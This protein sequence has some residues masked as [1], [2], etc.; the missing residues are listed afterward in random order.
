LTVYQQIAASV[1]DGSA[2]ALAGHAANRLH[3]AHPEV[4]QRF[5]REAFSGWRALLSVRI[6]ELATAVELESPELFVTAVDW[7]RAS[8]VARDVP[9]ED[10]QLAITALR[11]VLAEE[12]PPPM[13]VQALAAVDAALAVFERDSA[14]DLHRVPDED[15]NRRLAL[16]YLER[17]LSGDPQG[18]IRLVL[19]AVDNGLDLFDAYVDVIAAAQREVGTLWHNSQIG[20]HEEHLVTSTTL[21]LMTLLAHREKP[22][23]SVDKTMV[24]AALGDDSHDIGIRM[25]SDLFTIAGWR[26]ICLGGRLPAEEL[27]EAVSDFEADLL[28]VSATLIPHLLTVRDAIQMVRE[29][30]P[31]VRVL[32]GGLALQ[33][34][35]EVWKR[36]GADGHAADARSAVGVARGLV[37]LD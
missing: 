23:E 31:A 4:T 26:T 7:A 14:P 33:S 29:A 5:G 15:P 35:T 18:A 10:L 27:A 2:S 30:S 36:I 9:A 21:S 28:V 24:G 8:F 11:D 22:T 32:V 6:R 12:L 20:I 3:E 25:I 1:L 13:A 19:D 37:G 34:S 16:A 17:C